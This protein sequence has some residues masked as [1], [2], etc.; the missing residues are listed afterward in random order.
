MGNCPR[1]IETTYIYIYIYIIFNVDPSLI[2]P[3]AMFIGER[4]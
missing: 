4:G 3:G 2:T 1:S